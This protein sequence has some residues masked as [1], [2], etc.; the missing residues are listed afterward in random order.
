[1]INRRLLLI[2]VLVLTTLAL[3][4]FQSS[5]K[6]FHPLSMIQRPL[7]EI[8]SLIDNLYKG[9]RYPLESYTSLKHENKKLKRE[10][11]KLKI[12]VQEDREIQL[13]N[14]RLKRLLKIKRGSKAVVAVAEVV[15]MG[16]RQW[17]A[18][19]IINKGAD[20]G[21]KKGMA[22]RTADG[23][24][25][26]VTEVMPGY[27]KVLLI[28]DPNFSVSVRIEDTRTEGIVAG[29]GNG[30]CLLKYVPREEEVTRGQILITSGLDGVFPKGIPV[31]YIQKIA[32]ADEL[33]YTIEVMPFV[34]VG[35][36]EEVMIIK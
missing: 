5:R 30:R 36:L 35:R 29:K 22:V 34:K 11:E 27:S 33:F 18:V 23:L 21:I 7:L 12:M 28:T 31:G 20:D 3:M 1:M 19:I 2:A 6:P 24:V 9:V 14:E 25:G 4:V 16:V 32:G 15:S 17:P 13:E 10:L 26:K 8:V